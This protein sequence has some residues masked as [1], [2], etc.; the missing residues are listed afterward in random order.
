M[1]EQG[2]RFK[3][4]PCGYLKDKERYSH[5]T[6]SFWLSGQWKTFDES[7]SQLVILVVY[8][9]SYGYDKWTELKVNYAAKSVGN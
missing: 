7:F 2:T 6:H 4:K 8:S 9:N 3:W 1:P 5:C